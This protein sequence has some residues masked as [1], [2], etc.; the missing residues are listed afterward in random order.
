MEEEHF[1]M[2]NSFLLHYKCAFFKKK[3]AAK[4]NKKGKKKTSVS[5]CSKKSMPQSIKGDIMQVRP[6]APSSRR[7]RERIEIS[8]VFCEP[9]RPSLTTRMLLGLVCCCFQVLDVGE[10]GAR[11]L[12]SRKRER[13]PMQIQ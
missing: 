13:Y 8:P 2:G 11:A 1:R 4:E 6:V 5:H 9:P 7:R 12:I 10:D 3:K